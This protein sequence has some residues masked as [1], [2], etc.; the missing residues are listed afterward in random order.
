MVGIGLVVTGSVVMVERFGV[1]G[2]GEQKRSL[3]H[4][5]FAIKV[6]RISGMGRT[7]ALHLPPGF[8]SWE[9]VQEK[10]LGTEVLRAA[11]LATKA[12]NPNV[13][14]NQGGGIA[15]RGTG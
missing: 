10:V 13:A 7:Y 2:Q 11:I 14:L 1:S 15:D 12:P 3:D 6:G 9:K 4:Q 8:V 5:H